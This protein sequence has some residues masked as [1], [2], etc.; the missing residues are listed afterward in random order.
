M[1]SMM[2]RVRPTASSVL[3]SS[4]NRVTSAMTSKLRKKIQTVNKIRPGATTSN[5]KTLSIKTF[6]KTRLNI[7]TLNI[8]TLSITTFSIA[9]FRV[10]ALS[11]MTFS[12]MMNKTVHSA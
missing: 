6:S 7:L 3:A 8:T 9:I 1:T 11:I 10:T 12:M 4:K 5:T 2:V